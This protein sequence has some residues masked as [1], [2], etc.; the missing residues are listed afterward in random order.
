LNSPVLGIGQKAVIPA[1]PYDRD[2]KVGQLGRT[3]LEFAAA[4][5]D[6]LEKR[7]KRKQACALSKLAA[8]K[9]A[10]SIANQGASVSSA[11]FS[12]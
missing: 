11:A 6:E 7:R 1:N 10:A 5:I 12:R 3:V 9:R 8:I 2:G 4:F